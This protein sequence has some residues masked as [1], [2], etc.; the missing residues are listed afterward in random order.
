MKKAFYYK[1][2]LSFYIVTSVFMAGCSGQKSCVVLLPE[3]GKVSG[4]VTVT[5]SHGSQ[6]LKQS[7][8][9]TEI[10]G[11]DAGPSSPVVMEKAAVQ[12]AFGDALS[13][14]PLPPVH[15][16]LYFEL[17]TAILVPESE[18]LL[19]KIIKSIHDMH[20]AE[21]SVIGHADTV[22]TDE[23]NYQL[24]LLR[25]TRVAALLK[26][27]KAAPAVIEVYSHGESNLLIKTGDEAF[28]PRNR[29]VEVTVR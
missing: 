29:R 24:G 4:E 8:Q 19:P 10:A 16:M 9:A 26:S 11:V 5:N 6:I 22:G 7:W 25:A 3:D 13:A 15:Y 17:G 12:S 27:L 14:M 1:V 23:N 28:E 2:L 20:P 18:R 21:M